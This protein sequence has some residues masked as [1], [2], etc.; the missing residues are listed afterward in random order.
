M[1][2]DTTVDTR[3][4]QDSL[5]LLVVGVCIAGAFIIMMSKLAKGKK[6]A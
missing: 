5:I 4:N 6:T 3:I 2:I 1:T